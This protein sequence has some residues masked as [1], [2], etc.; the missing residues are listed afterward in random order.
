MAILAVA[1]VQGPVASAQGMAATAPTAAATFNIPAQPLPEALAQFARQ[2]GAQLAYPPDLVQ[3]R[4]A[5]PVQGA[6]SPDAALAELLRGSGLRMR[7]DGATLVL[8]R[9]PMDS[10]AALP[11]VRVAAEAE[12][13]TATGPVRGLVARR[14]ATA[15]KTDTR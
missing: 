11:E 6:R 14:S 1:A 9:A 15:T 10:N 2:S 13:E 12:V 4:R 3:G 7:R 8:E 5:Q